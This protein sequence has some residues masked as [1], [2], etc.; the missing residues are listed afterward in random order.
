MRKLYLRQKSQNYQPS[1][2]HTFHTFFWKELPVDLLALGFYYI[3]NFENYEILR[4][5]SGMGN[6]HLKAELKR[7][8]I[9]PSDLILPKRVVCPDEV[10]EYLKNEKPLHQVEKLIPDTPSDN[11]QEIVEQTPVN[12]EIAS[13]NIKDDK[14]VIKKE[15]DDTVNQAPVINFPVF[16]TDSSQHSLARFIVENNLITLV[17]QQGVFIV[18]G[19]KGKYCEDAVAAALHFNGRRRRNLSMCIYFNMLPY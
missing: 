3:Q 13:V 16:N 18:N 12:T 8:F 4:G 5:R 9:P 15:C 14:T 11:K 17:P 1:E 6:Y 19:Q 10:I 7:A 2:N